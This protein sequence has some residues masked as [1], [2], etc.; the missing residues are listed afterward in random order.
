MAGTD[1]TS[2][3]A[4]PGPTVILVRPQLG[5]NIGAAARAM[6]NCG[7]TELRL[8]DPRDGWPNPRAEA[9]ASGADGVLGKAQVFETTRKAVADLG[10]V[11]ASTARPRDM[12]KPVLTPRE[13][14]RE[15]HELSEGGPSC[16]VLFGP[17]RT[18]LE[19]EDVA[20][21]AAVMS[22]PLNPGFSSL[23]LGQAVLVF[24][25]EWFQ[26]IA[27]VADRTEPQRSSRS[28]TVAELENMFDHLI[29]HLD[30]SGF[31]R[32]PE[33]RPIMVRNL[34]NI[35][36][37]ARLTEQEVRTLHGVFAALAGQKRPP[38]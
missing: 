35:F 16:G 19:N 17:E 23:N 18:G 2:L 10:L 21:A 31:L 7:L 22:V 14:V 30:V 5:E 24:A 38:R 32:P 34:R 36:V 26:S 8:V 27:A 37:R 28:A 15:I 6:F 29:A 9:T 4:C 33:K 13:A 12:V 3:G 20:L 25:Y 1:R 11:L